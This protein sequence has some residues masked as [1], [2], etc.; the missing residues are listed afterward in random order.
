MSDCNRRDVEGSGRK[1]GSVVRLDI[2]REGS[3][4]RLR[5]GVKELGRKGRVVE[6]GYMHKNPLGTNTL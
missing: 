5:D 4:G 2:E 3:K 1:F 6:D